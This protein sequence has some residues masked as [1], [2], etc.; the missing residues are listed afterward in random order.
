MEDNYAYPE[1]NYVRPDGLYARGICE[2]VGGCL[3]LLIWGE[4]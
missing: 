3:P 4:I 1:E 2:G